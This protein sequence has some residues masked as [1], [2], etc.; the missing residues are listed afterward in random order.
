M[1]KKL[2]IEINEILLF[3]KIGESELRNLVFCDFADPKAD[4]R[5]YR[6]CQDLELLRSIVENYLNEYNS[7]SKKPMNLVLFRFAIEHLSKISRIIKQPRSHALLVGVGGSGRQ[8]L[9][10]LASHI[11]D[12]EVHQIELSKQYNVYD[13]HEDVKTI[14]QKTTSSENHSTF[15]FTDSQI[16]EESFLEDINNMLNTGEVPN[17]FNNE[18]KAAI[19]EKMRALDRQRDKALQTD[20]SS[21]ALFNLFVQIAR[22][23]LHIVVAMSPIGDAFRNRIRKF[24]ALVNCCTIDWMQVNIAKNFDCENENKI[25]TIFIRLI[26][27]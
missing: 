20:G 23:Q 25:P 4:V 17:L 3:V 16:K 15:L 8:S 19:C 10:R 24:P 18:E 26:L 13:W 7:V 1:K 9:T 11:S 22:D 21:V 27:A 14:L 6:E 5:L 12:Y 2:K